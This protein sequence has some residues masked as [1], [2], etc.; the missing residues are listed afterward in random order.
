MGIEK[1]NLNG[2]QKYPEKEDIH[3]GV[4]NTDKYSKERAWHEE[5]WR[6]KSEDSKNILG[7]P[8]FTPEEIMR[9]EADRDNEYFDRLQHEEYAAWQADLQPVIDGFMEKANNPEKECINVIYMKGGGMKSAY[10]GGQI[11]AL[12]AMGITSD[13]VDYIFGSSSGS[14]TAAAYAGGSEETNKGL[15]ML[16]G[17]LSSKEFISAKRILSGDIIK[18]EL[19]E[20]IMSEGE[21]A[22]DEEKIREFKGRLFFNVTEPTEG[23]EVPIV[24]FLDMKNTE[25]NP[26][27]PS[28]IRSSMS[29]GSR[30]TGEIPEID[31]VKYQD[32]DY[33]TLP[34][35]EVIAKVKETLPPEMSGVEINVLILPQTPF[36]VID[37]IK[38]SQIEYNMASL[39]K[40]G[41]GSA[42]LAD[43]RKL[44]L[45]REGLRRDLEEIQEIEHVKIGI[46]WPPNDEL[47]STNIDSDEAK[48][49]IISS[50]RDTIKQ[51]GGEQPET[52]SFN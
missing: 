12:N 38:P 9:Q 1:I 3:V 34:M 32:G 40:I 14:V 13:K 52:I 41:R 27:I 4:R 31:G 5:R 23:D 29:I 6:S 7:K 21:F 30:V 19:A 33:N 50:A 37:D 16:T 10:T 45:A 39:G 24:R 18:L 15:R 43:A 47:T 2:A 22:L 46:M 48:A 25:D 20:Q 35:A 8:K 49:S 44:L 28:R 17:P 42:S 51:F 11:W 26:S 36:E